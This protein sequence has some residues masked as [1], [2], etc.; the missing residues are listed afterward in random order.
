MLL[1]GSW[2]LVQFTF[3]DQNGYFPIR[4]IE[5]SIFCMNQWFFMYC[6]V[7]PVCICVPIPYTCVL[8]LHMCVCVGVCIVPAHCRHRDEGDRT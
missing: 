4:N 8:V 3:E 6:H 1:H 2:T 7:V 5:I